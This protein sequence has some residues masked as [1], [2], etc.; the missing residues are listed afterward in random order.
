MDC[1]GQN[2][3]DYK[4]VA[5]NEDQY[6]MVMSDFNPRSELLCSHALCHYG[7]AHSYNQECNQ[8]HG[9]LEVSV[10]VVIFSTLGITTDR[11]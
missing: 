8:Y 10:D 5:D 3:Q 11:C 2:P 7:H 4:E 1:E 6:L 9:H